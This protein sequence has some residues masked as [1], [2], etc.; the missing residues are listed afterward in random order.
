MMPWSVTNESED[1][2]FL[3]AHLCEKVNL[4]MFHHIHEQR[5]LS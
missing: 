5:W 3:F 4:H 1:G 2:T